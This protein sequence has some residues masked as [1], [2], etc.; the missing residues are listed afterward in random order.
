MNVTCRL[1]VMRNVMA[2]QCHTLHVIK[3]MLEMC[4][5]TDLALQVMVM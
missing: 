5:A 3:I 1:G 2:M 4:N